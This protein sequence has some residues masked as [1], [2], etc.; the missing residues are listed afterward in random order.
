M[1][2]GYRT[3]ILDVPASPDELEHIRVAFERAGVRA[4]S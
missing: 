2:A 4:G 3:F 1:A